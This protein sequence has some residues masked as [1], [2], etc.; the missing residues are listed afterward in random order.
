MTKEEAVPGLATPW[1]DKRKWP[2]TRRLLAAWR[3]E[4]E[5]GPHDVAT[6]NAYNSVTC[7]APLGADVLGIDEAFAKEC[8]E[9]L[10]MEDFIP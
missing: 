8:A 3:W 4:H 1:P 2:I 5:K 10:A 9:L 6:R 7:K